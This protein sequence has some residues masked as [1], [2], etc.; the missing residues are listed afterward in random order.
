MPGQPLNCEVEAATDND[1][2]TQG[3][4][5]GC[6]LD[7]VIYTWNCLYGTFNGGGSTASGRSV[8][9]TAP[10]TGCEEVITC[11]ISDGRANTDP[12]YDVPMVRQ[13]QVIVPSV[14]ILVRRCG[15]G[16]AFSNTCTIAA[17][18]CDSAEQKADVRIQLTP[19][20]AGIPVN[21]PQITGGQGVRVGSASNDAKIVLDDSYISYMEDETDG[22]YVTDAFGRVEGTY[23]GSNVS[24][25]NAAG[26]NTP[27]LLGISGPNGAGVTAAQ[28]TQALP[29]PPTVSWWE[30]SSF[31][32]IDSSGALWTPVAFHACFNDSA[33]NISVPVYGHQMRFQVDRVDVSHQVGHSGECDLIIYTTRQN[34]SVPGAVVHTVSSLDALAY[35]APGV[36]SEQGTAC[37]VSQLGILAQSDPS[38]EVVGVSYRAVDETVWDGN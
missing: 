10:S 20:I 9:Y 23:W 3:T 5:S 21:I 2:W 35:F 11:T 7:A 38:D 15:S 6:E 8:T 22:Q 14:Q 37:Y 29:D 31:G 13:V 27:V 28:I 1:H 32:T 18:G 24:T 25:A 34:L 12:R 16:N 17:G 33:A 4:A 36:A 19:A 26:T 30:K